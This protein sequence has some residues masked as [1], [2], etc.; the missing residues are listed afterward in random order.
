M[1]LT[2]SNQELKRELNAAA[3]ALDYTAH[4]LF[5]GAETY[6]DAAFTASMERIVALHGHIDRLRASL[7]KSVMVVLCGPILN[8]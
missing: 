2:K 1:G 7:R 5:R 3:S 6:G 8:S 4:D